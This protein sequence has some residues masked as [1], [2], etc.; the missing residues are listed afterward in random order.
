MAALISELAKL[1]YRITEVDNSSLIW[2]G[3]TIPTNKKIEIET[4]KDHRMAMAFAPAAKF[5]PGITI[6]DAGV[7]SK[8]YP[9]YWK[10]LQ[11]IG[12]KM[13]E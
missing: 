2:D 12:F 13:E 4:Y 11:K 9:E 3:S 6:L 8:S 1:G 10:H 7:V 5:L